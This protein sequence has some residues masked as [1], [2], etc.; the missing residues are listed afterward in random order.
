[1]KRFLFI[2]S[3]E[4][5]HEGLTDHL[6]GVQPP[7]A[8]LGWRIHFWLCVAC[9]ALLRGFRALPG[10]VREGSAPQAEP[11]AEARAALSGVLAGLRAGHDH[12]PRGGGGA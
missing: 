5:V 11:S 10:L 8:R 3:C 12:H 7:L 9:R 1:M 6:E 2:P 4:E